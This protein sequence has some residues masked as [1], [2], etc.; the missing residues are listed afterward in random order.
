MLKNFHDLF[1]ELNSSEVSFCNWK[2][3]STVGSHL[4]G[5][6]DLDLFVSLR[7]KTKF[8]KIIEDK[9]FK[10]VIS[11]QANHDFIEHFYG[12]DKITNK[13]VHVHVYFKIVTGE[14]ISKNYILPLEHFILT[15]LDNS[16]LLPK[17]SVI[18]QHV[19]FLIRYYLKI[20]SFYGFLQ[21]Q[22]EFKKY[23]D[24]WNYINDNCDYKIVEE[25]DLS[26]E[27]LNEMT[28]VYKAPNFLRKLF[29]SRNLKRK[30]RNYKVRSHFLYQVYVFNNFVRR[31]L[32]KWFFKKKKLFIPGI[33]V[34]VCGLDGCGKSSLVS[35]LNDNFEEHFSVK[36]LHVGRPKSN[37]LTFS[38]NIFIYFYSLLKRKKSLNGETNV[39]EAPKKISIIYAIRSVLL[40][41]DRKI[42]TTNA[43]KLSKKGYLVIC[44]RYPGLVVG[45][46]D[47]PRISLDSNRSLVYQLCYL[48]EQKLYKS[49][50][51][52]NLIFHLQVPLEI[53]IFRNNKRKKN[54]KETENE[55]RDRFLINSDAVFLGDNYHFFNASKPFKAVLIEATDAI[56]HSKAWDDTQ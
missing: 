17:P 52:A 8:E 47:S 56:W 55:L 53:A 46:M 30:L 54:G 49:I 43:H 27:C 21:Y 28:G 33:V 23:S 38:F 25:L 20:G 41:Y 26:I 44:D 6:G 40:A 36:T 16:S 35:A 19:I 34:A 3:H 13:F 50:K 9:G 24:E 51:Q 10:R 2:G 39:F 5:G 18:A 29:L 14:H 31:L 45:K 32:N 15:D 7:H 42:V 22:R 4:N 1:T 48:I 11:Y 37:I 12:L